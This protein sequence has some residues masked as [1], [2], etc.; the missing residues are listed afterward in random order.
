MNHKYVYAKENLKGLVLV[1]FGCRDFYIRDE[2]HSTDT[3]E[4]DK[5]NFS[6]H[7]F[8]YHLLYFDFLFYG[9]YKMA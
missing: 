7:R 4:Y 5:R 8:L 9:Y 6:F 2:N 3:A 1:I